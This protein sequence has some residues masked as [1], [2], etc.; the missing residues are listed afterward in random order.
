MPKPFTDTQ[1]E[2]LRQKLEFVYGRT[3]DAAEA[4]E[5][6]ERLFNLYEELRG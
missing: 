1:I 4:Q 2:D 3:F 6:A 5:I